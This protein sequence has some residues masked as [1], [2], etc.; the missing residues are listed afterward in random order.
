VTLVAGLIAALAIASSDATAQPITLQ[1][2]QVAT[3][4]IPGATAAVS[5]DPARVTASVLDGV[6]TLVGRA[7]GS[8]NVVVIAGDETITLRV[9]VGDPPVVVLPGMRTSGAANGSSGYYEGRFGS[10]PG[11]FQG[12]LFMSRRDGDRTAELTLGGASPL[13]REIG[14]AFTIPRATFTLRSP[15]REI[16]LFDRVI[17]NSPLTV[18]HSNVRG[19]FLR[20]GGWQLNA[21]YSFFSTFEHLLLPTD[22]EAVAGLAYRHRL[23]PSSTLTPNLFYFDGGAEGGRRGALGTV[24]YERR[25]AAATKM[26]AELGLSRSVGG[27]LEIEHDGPNNRAWAKVRIA[28]ADLPSLTTDHQSG[29]QIEGGWIWQ[30]EKTGINSLFSSR[31]YTNGRFDQTSRVA[32]FDAH[33]RVTPRWAIHAGSGMSM[34]ETGNQTASTISNV[35]LPF[36]TSYSAAHGGIGVD[37]QFSR[38]TTRDL[39]GHLVRVSANGSAR[40]FRLSAYGERQTQTPTARQ[41]L[42]DVPWLQLMLDRLGLVASTPQQLA[43]L[44]RTNAE[45]AAYGYANSLQL[46]VTPVRM[47][48]GASGGWIGSGALRPQLTLNTL[49]N[50]DETIERPSLAAVHSLTYQQRLDGATD[51]Y[52]T[53]SSLCQGGY[54]TRSCRPALFGSVRRSL[55]SSPLLSARR[56]TIEG[57]VFR[58]DQAS[59]KYSPGLPVMAGVEVIL[60]NV[61]SAITDS[62]GRFRFDD[63]VYGRHRVEARDRSGQPTF[64]TTPSPIEV[65]TGSSIQ[66]GLARSRSTLRGVVLT[67]R[68]TGV[69]GVLINITGRDRRTTVRTADDGSFVEEG[70]LEGTYD[71]SIDGGSVPAGYPVN[72]LA[73]QQVDVDYDSPGRARF[74]LRPHRSVVGRAKLFNRESGQYSALSNVTVELRPLQRHSV[75]DAL[76]QYAF[77]DLPAGDYT[78]V[79][80]HDGREHTIAVT[81]PEGPALVKDIDLAVLPEAGAA[82]ASATVVATTAD[83]P[84]SSDTFTIQV[85]ESS[86]A[87]HARAMV[88]ELKRAGHAAYVE[89]SSSD[90]ARQHRVRVGRYP[91]VQDA[92]QAAQALEKTL[93]W[94]VSVVP[95]AAH[96]VARATASDSAR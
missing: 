90:A 69:P 44:V 82:V 61:R 88:D 38:E 84:M 36:G 40:G 71:V 4:Q 64:F 27:A 5:L 96:V 78:V 32:T 52:F 15:R 33:R 92:T 12:L 11:V 83:A 42:T 79:V 48:V 85:A 89:P 66:F 81:V 51:L 55:N 45:L 14:P 28:P 54:V 46:D 74:V 1:Y 86:S 49:F 43:D 50:R 34:F 56:G 17:T 30:G 72:A 37:Y 39:G 91:R 22:K 47:R 80:R 20:E 25:I 3:R 63:V 9:D 41:I 13:D 24:L 75:T 26:L 62:A 8:T 70:L 59:G 58:D 68:G 57:L 53:W 60:D 67:D 7:P 73:P 2:Q 65:D 87:R 10:D 21:G 6:V 19:I 18:S 35:T 31:R 93:G 94:Q 29:D 16:T 23:T 77:R 76:G 95:L